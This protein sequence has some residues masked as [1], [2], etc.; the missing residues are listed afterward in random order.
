[1]KMTKKFL[2]GAVALVAATLSLASCK[3]V[4]DENKEGI[5]T[6]GPKTFNI[7]YKNEGESVIR[8][9]KTTTF[10]HTGGTVEIKD[11]N[12][13]TNGGV[14]GFIWDLAEK[15][16]KKSFI[17]AGVVYNRST[18]DS[19]EVEY[20]CSKYAN[21]TDIQAKN[22]GATKTFKITGSTTEDK[23][24]IED[25][26]AAVAAG[27]VCEL[28]LTNGFQVLYTKSEVISNQ[29]VDLVL[30]IIGGDGDS[31]TATAKGTYDV[32]IYE[33]G[34]YSVTSTDTSKAKKHFNIGTEI[35]GYKDTAVTQKPL[36]IYANVYSKMS[37]EGSWKFLKD[38]NY[39]TIEE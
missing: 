11:E 4:A 12:V 29:G 30:D 22:F 15:D 38:Y 23:K 2:I 35:T 16:G 21:V 20:Y 13:T 17:I 27:T 14:Q 9:Y 18:S 36:A 25:F 33:N 1:M 32:Y 10:K 19:N 3:Q 26:N 7:N 31:K 39:A 37:M 6:G 5:I 28:D 24:A 34:D 8:A